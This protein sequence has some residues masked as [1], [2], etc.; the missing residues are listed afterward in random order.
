M[1]KAK[2]GTCNCP[3]CGEQDGAQ[4]GTSAK[5][6]AYAVCDNCGMQLFTRSRF[7]H[8]RLMLQVN[9]L[10]PEPPAATPKA[11]KPTAPPKPEPVKEIEDDGFLI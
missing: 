10:E 11:E 4:V 6:Y 9:D 8:E 2:I 5:G 3:V 1:A 7:A